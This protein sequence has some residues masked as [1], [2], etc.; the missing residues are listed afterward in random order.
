MADIEDLLAPALRR[1][2]GFFA[3]TLRLR[4]A[5]LPDWLQHRKA[6]GSIRIGALTAGDLTVHGVRSRVVWEGGVVQLDGLQGRLDEGLFKGPGHARHHQE[7]AA[8]Q[9]ARPSSEL[10][11]EERQGRHVGSVETLGSGLDLLLNLRGEGTFQA[12][13]MYSVA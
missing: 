11:V 8:V 6:E 1:D 3:R 10:S 12:R 5:A 13:G 4:R 9:A 7:R 2:E